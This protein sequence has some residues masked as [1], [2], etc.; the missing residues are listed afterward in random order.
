MRQPPILIF[1]DSKAKIQITTE[2][3]ANA[4]AGYLPSVI[5]GARYDITSP[6]WQGIYK[7]H[8]IYKITSHLFF[9][10]AF[11]IFM[12][13]LYQWA[14]LIFCFGIVILWIS[15]IGSD[16]KYSRLHTFNI[17][18]TTARGEVLFET[19]KCYNWNSE[20]EKHDDTLLEGRCREIVAAIGWSIAAGKPERNPILA[21]TTD[22]VTPEKDSGG[23][24]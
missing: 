23:P 6:E 5:S 20:G 13:Q 16:E 22:P 9:G 19:R 1:E 21:E 2:L 11:F 10:V 7:W 3:I 24:E 17:Y 8:R 18:L 15:R 4:N 12:C 14:A